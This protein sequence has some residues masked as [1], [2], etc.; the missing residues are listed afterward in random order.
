MKNSGAYI[1][2]IRLDNTLCL[3]VGRLG[4]CVFNDGY[5]AYAGSALGGLDARLKRHLRKDKKL[6][7]HIDFLLM[8]AFI[9]QIWYLLS[10]IKLECSLN[11]ILS[12]MPGAN[13]P[14]KGFGSSDCTCRTHLV[15]FL[16]EPSYYDF[17]EVL[18]SKGL[19]GIH[20]LTI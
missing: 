5:Y 14:I 4:G 16:K 15:H 11:A 10:E 17:S 19:E 7:W 12:E 6:N 18:I 20:R 8:Q 3:P 2:I 13:Q 9:I 1:L